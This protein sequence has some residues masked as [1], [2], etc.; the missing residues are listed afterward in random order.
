M[1]DNR[2]EEKS[3]LWVFLLDCGAEVRITMT[4]THYHQSPLVQGGLKIP[5]KQPRV[6]TKV[7]GNSELFMCGTYK[8]RNY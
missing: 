1:I 2:K 3:R 6:A 8:R 7:S 5:C 4:G